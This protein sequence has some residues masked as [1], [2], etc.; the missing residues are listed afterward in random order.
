MRPL[1]QVAD[2]PLTLHKPSWKSGVHE[3][4]A[5]DET[6]GTLDVSLW[7]GGSVATVA[8]HSWRFERPRGFLRRSVRVLAGIDDGLELGRYAGSGLGGRGG[9]L[10]LGERDYALHARG[11]FKPRWS[12]SAGGR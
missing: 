4:R 3:L 2:L 7:S 9:V 8:D 12:W 6:V 10:E 1:S 11:F 5:G